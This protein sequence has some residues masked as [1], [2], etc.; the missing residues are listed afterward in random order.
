MPA[1]SA[2]TTVR[3]ANTRPPAGMPK[4][5]ASSSAFSA[6]AM[7]KPAR[8]PITDASTPTTSASIRTEASTC[9]RV[10]PS[11][12]SSPFCRV[13]CATVIEKVLKIMNA[14]TSSATT[15]KNSMK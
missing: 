14:P 9:R 12:R 3:G 6:V 7:P 11:A 1:A 2:T 15:A 8:R 13:R 10:A 5:S 4:P